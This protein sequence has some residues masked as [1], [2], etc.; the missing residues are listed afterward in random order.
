MSAIAAQL[1]QSIS[2]RLPNRG[3]ARFALLLSIAIGIAVSTF[4]A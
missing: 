3:E 1:Q 2:W 4:A